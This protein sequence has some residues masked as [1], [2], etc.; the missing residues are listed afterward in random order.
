MKLR[1]ALSKG[2]IKV[3][4]SQQLKTE[5]DPGSHKLFSS[6]LEFQAMGNVHNLSDSEYEIEFK[7]IMGSVRTASVV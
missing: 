6:Y 3:S 5:S 4:P 2:P 1:L 7:L